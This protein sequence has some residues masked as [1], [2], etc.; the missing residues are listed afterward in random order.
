MV[1][2]D[3]KHVINLNNASEQKVGKVLKKEEEEQG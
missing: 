1:L 3:E 2:L